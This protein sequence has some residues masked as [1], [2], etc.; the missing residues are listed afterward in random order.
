VGLA[1]M[2]LTHAN[3]HDLALS[4][5]PCVSV[6]AGQP[7]QACVLL[8][9]QGLRRGRYG[10]LLAGSEHAE[11]AAG[12]QST[13]LLSV[14]TTQRGWLAFPRW[15]I[16]STYPLGLFRAWA[17]WR[18]AP[19]ALV[20]PALEPHAPPL[21]G[22]AADASQ[23]QSLPASE[24]STPDEVREWRRGDPLS[25]VAWKKSA[26]R[27]ASGQSPVS[28]FRSAQAGPPLW[29]DWDATQGLHTEARLSR[30]AAWL[31]MAETQAQHTGQPYGLKL[32]GH[33]LPCT[34]GS[35]HL[36][37]ALDT[38][39]QW[40]LPGLPPADEAQAHNGGAKTIEPRK[41]SEARP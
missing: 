21:P 12:Q 40:G 24:S 26:T 16:E 10:L 9:A 41:V 29:I 35:A 23:G 19:A 20:W 37:Q 8:D 3:L 25:A 2:W 31:V 18:A 4:L 14:P 5:G 15:R 33:T 32:P 22:G 27:L 30:L 11:V 7:L 17:Y 13:A 34:L 36:H 38:L 28:R 39:A 6:H 1:A